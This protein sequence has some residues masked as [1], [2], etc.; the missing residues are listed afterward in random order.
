MGIKVRENIDIP[1]MME[2]FCPGCGY[3]HSP[4]TKSKNLQGA[5]W[6][7]NGNLE[8]PTFT[9][10]I[11][12]SKD[13]PQYRCHSFVTDGRIQFLDDCFHELK[14]KTVDLPDWEF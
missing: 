6:T 12:V 11:L 5:Q 4:T 7:F 2:F 8:K 14:N 13:N 9:P 1:G 10:S 3:Y